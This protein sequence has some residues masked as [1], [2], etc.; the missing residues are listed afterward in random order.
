MNNLVYLNAFRKL[1]DK[2]VLFLFG[3]PMPLTISP[4]QSLW[5]IE[6][7]TKNYYELINGRWLLNND[8]YRFDVYKK[9]AV[10]IIEAFD[11]SKLKSVVE[12]D[13]YNDA[14]QAIKD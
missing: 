8:Y 13:I 11:L 2:Y 7:K 5:L 9:D 10:D 12:L 6:G 3:E 14:I 4:V 1:R